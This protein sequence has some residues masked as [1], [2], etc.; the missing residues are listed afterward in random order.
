MVVLNYPCLILGCTPIKL[1]WVFPGVPL[2]VN[3]EDD[4]DVHI[5][6]LTAAYRSMVHPSTGFSLNFLMLGREVTTPTDLVFQCPSCDFADVPEYV[7]VLQA[8]FENWYRRARD[9]L[10]QA[11]KCQKKTHD[12]WMA[13]VCYNAGQAILK[14]SQRDSKFAPRYG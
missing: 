9:R 7:H 6:I 1:P 4:W 8:T 12:T 13:Q 3:H 2:K 5:V 14:M 10:H 11:A